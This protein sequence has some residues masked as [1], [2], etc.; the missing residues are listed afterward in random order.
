MFKY[1]IEKNLIF[2]VVSLT[3]LMQNIFFKA[4][5]YT[6]VTNNVSHS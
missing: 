6:P 5:I 4:Y 1:Q 2:D 3:F